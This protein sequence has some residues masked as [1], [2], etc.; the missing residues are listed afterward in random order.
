VTHLDSTGLCTPRCGR[1]RGTQGRAWAPFHNNR[2]PSK[3]RGMTWR[4]RGV[5]RS[6]QQKPVVT[7]G[8]CGEDRVGKPWSVAWKGLAL[9]AQVGPN[10]SLGFNLAL[11]PETAQRSCEDGV[12]QEVV[13]ESPL[14]RRGLSCPQEAHWEHKALRPR[15]GLDKRTTVNCK[16]LWAHIPTSNLPGSPTAALSLRVNVSHS[17]T[18]PGGISL[19]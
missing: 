8:C 9:H 19:P 18:T 2:C 14:R 15:V 13:P 5:S 11:S 17:D 6:M 1:G 16:V 7:L 10:G 12:S 4:R 3:A